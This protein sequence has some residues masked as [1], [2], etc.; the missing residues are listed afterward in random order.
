MHTQI[1]QN[2]EWFQATQIPK[3]FLYGIPGM[4]LKAKNVTEIQ[5]RFPNLQSVPVGKGKHYLQKTPLMRSVKPSTHGY[6][7]Q[8]TPNNRWV[9]RTWL[10]NSG[11]RP[12]NQPIF[13]RW[14]T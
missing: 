12:A 3:L 8:S 7:K 1:S 13:E 4:I 5:D 14:Q 6:G 10:T 9:F 2:Y 11:Y